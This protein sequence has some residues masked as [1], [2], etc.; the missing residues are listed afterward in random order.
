MPP[1]KVTTQ[2]AG[3]AAAT[4]TPPKPIV[5]NEPIFLQ[6]NGEAVRYVPLDIVTSRDAYAASL[7]ILFQHIATFHLQVIEL[8]AE[9]YNLDVEEIIGSI[10]TDPRFQELTNNPVIQSMGYF[11]RDGNCAHLATAAEPEKPE[12][13]VV[14]VVAAA[15]V[16]QKPPPKRIVVRKKKVTTPAQEQP[17]PEDNS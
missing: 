5:K 14:E 11:D 2:A 6:Q 4:P 3:S 12:V 9:K 13:K 10:Q 7:H 1:K 16:D 8:L 15:T 17:R